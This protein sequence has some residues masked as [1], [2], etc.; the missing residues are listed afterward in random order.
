MYHILP[1]ISWP[2]ANCIYK[3][4]LS[5]SLIPYVHQLPPWERERERE[6]IVMLIVWLPERERERFNQCHG[7]APVA[8]MWGW[9][10]LRFCEIFFN[11]AIGH[12]PSSVPTVSVSCIQNSK[13]LFNF[14][15]CF[16]PSLSHTHVQCVRHLYSR[17]FGLSVL[18][19]SRARGKQME[20]EILCQL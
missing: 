14:Q 18:L 11:K 19:R 17:D 20:K 8:E 15:T 1:Y 2:R 9:A 3:A 13:Y 7:D 6:I 12:T 4:S 10:V 16:R 5:W